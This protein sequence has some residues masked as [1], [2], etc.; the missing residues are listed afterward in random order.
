MTVDEAGFAAAMAHQRAEARK[1]WA[2]SGEA[3]TDAVWFGLRD[4]VGPTE[5]L[6]YAVEATESIVTALLE[7]GH[8]TDR[9]AA[10]Q[11]GQLL[12]NQTPFYA[13]SGG[14]VGDSGMLRA[15]GVLAKVTGTSKKLGDLFVHDVE[16]IDGAIMPGMPL[17]AEVDHR[18]RS[19]IRANHSATHLLHEALRQVLGPHVAQKGSLVDPDR[20]RFDFSHQK[21]IGPEELA[22][23]EEIANRIVLQNDPVLT[24]IMGIED[25]RASGARALFGE[26]YGDEVR[27]V[28]MGR[29][30]TGPAGVPY[31]IELCGGT[32]VGRTGDIGLVTVV[33]EGAV[34][35]G[36]RR[37]EAK[38]G[39]AARRHLNAE[40]AR[41]RDL[42]GL[43]K[44]SP[45]LAADRLGALVEDR[46][47]LERELTDAR[48]KL[49][50]G[51]GAGPDGAA[52]GSVRI[53]GGVNLMSRAVTGIEM[54][55]LKSLADEAKARLGSGVVAIVGVGPD[56]KAGLV[57]AVTP[58]LTARINAVDLVR[59]SAACLGGKG[60]GG[61]PDMAQ[62]GGPDGAQAQAALDAVAEALGRTES[63]AA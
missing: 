29:G 43:L 16:V 25:A 10:G 17:A 28:S 53:V 7:S 11:S 48:K 37:I 59:A 26:K 60:G 56:G 63:A 30:E 51:G 4:R 14:Q 62:A 47:R 6:G 33:G 58:D 44:A 22:E 24:R 35:A 55:D 2:G 12:L 3:A 1:A 61:R 36:I 15:P 31:S 8:E 46:R 45:D 18:R 39:H 13:E 38:T 40:S 23:V 42:A 5:F 57:V 20:L 41:L 9:L 21:P 27:V 49:A 50:L 34:G 19:A 54:K 52:A 32:H